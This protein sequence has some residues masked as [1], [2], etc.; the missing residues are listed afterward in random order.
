VAT[1]EITGGVEYEFGAQVR[2]SI[3]V[4]QAGVLLDPSGE[5]TIILEEPDG[6]EITKIYD[7]GAGDVVRSS[8]GSFYY[9]HTITKVGIHEYRWKTASPIGVRES[10]FVALASRVANP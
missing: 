10:Y 1:T 8:V 4:K 3:T 2:L 5:V 7:G 6:T 9:D